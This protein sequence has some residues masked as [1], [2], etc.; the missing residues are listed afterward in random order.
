MDIWRRFVDTVS[1]VMTNNNKTVQVGG[2]RIQCEADKVALRF[3]AGYNDEGEAGV[4][5]TASPLQ[6]LIGRPNGFAG[7]NLED[8]ALGEASAQLQS[9]DLQAR[10]T[11]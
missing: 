11:M 5:R 1:N 6:L 4:W 7:V 3:A 9:K 8:G 10:L 2:E